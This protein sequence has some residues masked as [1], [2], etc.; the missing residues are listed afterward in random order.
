MSVSISHVVQAQK[1]HLLLLLQ[2]K[3]KYLIGEKRRK[4]NNPDGFSLT[5]VQHSA[6]SLTVSGTEL[7]ATITNPDSYSL[8][9]RLETWG[10]ENPVG[11]K[12]SGLDTKT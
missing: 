9:G 7:K 6:G 5:W 2:K 8:Y 12:T 11:K 1:Q 4:Q 3:N 10:L